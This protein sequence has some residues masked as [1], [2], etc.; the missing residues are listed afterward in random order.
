MNDLKKRLE[1][2]QLTQG[3]KIALQSD[4]EALSY[5]S[6]P[7]EINNISELFNADRVGL[8]MDNGLP[9]AL[10]D[11]ALFFSQKCTVPLPDFFSQEQLIHSISNAGLDLI[12]TD[13][14]ERINAL[15]IKVKQ[16]ESVVI[17]NTTIDIFYL[18][19]VQQQTSIPSAIRKI[20]YTSG[21]TGSPKGVMLSEN[22]IINKVKSMAQASDATQNDTT[23]S[24]LPLSTLL[25]NIGGLYLPLF[26]GATAYLASSQTTGLSGSSH[27]NVEKLLAAISRIQPTAF[28]VIPQLLLLLV[29]SARSGHALPNSLRF[30]AVG[31]APVSENLLDAARQFELPVY[32]GYGLSE[33]ASVVSLNNKYH[34]KP[35]SVGRVLSSHQITI[36]DDGEIF[37]KHNLFDGYL[38]HSK[39]QVNEY[40]ASGD[41]GYINEEGY[42]YVQGRKKNIINT[43]YGRNIS[44]EWLEKELETMPCVAQSVVYGHARPFIIA[45]VVLRNP[46]LESEFKQLLAQLNSNLPD[47]AQIQDYLILPEPYSI[48]NQQL[49]GTGHPI[50]TSIYQYYQNNINK[51]YEKSA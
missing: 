50:R 27:V 31:G 41:L 43:S 37:I 18:D 36:A 38:G 4:H 1:Q 3:D 16:Q 15:G 47:Y 10:L 51:L 6:L 46:Q 23:L 8:L 13:K 9:W 21:S 34:N 11:L 42:L 25:E 40:Y 12:I 48:S 35:G 30:I 7:G 49:T 26:C 29:H 44:P 19:N 45:L 20:T 5:N 32:Q 22:S 17:S 24:L 39:Q 2:Y 14:P 33:A 28:I